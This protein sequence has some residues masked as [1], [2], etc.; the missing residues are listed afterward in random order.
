[1]SSLESPHLDDSDEYT[2][3]IYTILYIKKKIALNYPKSASKGFFLG[4]KNDFETAVV[5]KPS[6]FEPLGR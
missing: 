4:T 5:N 1:M 6:V 3:F 2:P